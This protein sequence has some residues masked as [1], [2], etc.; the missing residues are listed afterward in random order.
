M[1][2]VFLDLIIENNKQI[3]WTTTI[4]NDRK[5]KYHTL[6]N[7]PYNL[8]SFSDA[9]AHL[10]NMAFYNFPLKM[11]KEV[12]DSI[13]KGNP[14]MPMEKCIW[15]LTKELGDWFEIDR[16]YL[17]EGKVA[18]LVILNPLHFN[19]ITEDV[20]TG[21]IKGFNNYERLVNR[22]AGAVAEV[23]VKGKTIFKDDEF[24]D[25][26]GTDVKFGEFVG[27]IIIE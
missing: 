18:D 23:M 10:N 13:D 14:I 4:G 21:I 8:I 5:E 26:Y 17:S 24:V 15:R 22:N 20:E 11:I 19:K 12:Q 7:L 3:K 9:G 6:Y 27:R 16:G 1:V 25:G 2:D